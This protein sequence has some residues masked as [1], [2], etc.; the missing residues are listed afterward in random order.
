MHMKF[1]RVAFTLTVAFKE[2]VA[3]S[4]SSKEYL[5]VPGNMFVSFQ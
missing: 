3:L 2:C 4:L 5:P 1:S